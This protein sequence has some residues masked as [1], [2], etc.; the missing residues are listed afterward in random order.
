MALNQYKAV[1]V[2]QRG[3]IKHKEGTIQEIEEWI[4]SKFGSMAVMFRTEFN[5]IN[6]KKEGKLIGV[7]Y[8]CTDLFATVNFKCIAIPLDIYEEHFKSSFY[9]RS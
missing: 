4:D 9:Q 3:P 6:L 5:P 8:K 2:P 1:F 7:G